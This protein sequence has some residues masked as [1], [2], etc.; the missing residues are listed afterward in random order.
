MTVAVPPHAVTIR[1]FSPGSTWLARLW[2]H[3]WL[4]ASV[5]VA[6]GAVTALISSVPMPRGPV[7]SGEGLIVIGVSVV[8]GVVAGYLMRSR[9]ALLLAPLAYVVTYELARLGIAGATMDGFRF[10]TVYGIAAF[11]VGRGFHGLLALFP[12]VVGV[13]IGLAVARPRR[14]LSLLPTGILVAAVVGLAV[15]VA[16]P[17]STPP[18]LGADGQPVPGSIA[19]LSTVELGG[20]EQGISIRAS[21]PD[22]PVLLYL[23]G[24]PGQTD[25]AFGRVLL[26][27]LTQDF[28]VVVWDQR[29]TGMSYGALDP[30]ESATLDQAVADTIELSTYL[31]ARFDEERIYLLGESWGTTLGVLAAQE[32]PDLYHAYIGSGQMVSQR[33][34]DQIIW[35]DLLAYADRSGDGQLY[36]QIL[37]LGEPPYRDTP[38]A[39][40]IVMG[41]YPLLE[42]PYTPPAAYVERGTASD[43]GPYT[44]LASEY[45]FV[46]KANV[47]RGLLDTFSIMYPQL[48]PIDFRADVPELEVPVW[49]LDGANEIRGRRELALEWFEQ[50]AAPSKEL[51]TYA[52]AGH[53]V[54]FEQADAFHRLMVDEIVPA[55]YGAA[56]EE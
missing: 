56:G 41:Y 19:E 10:D 4:G 28:V 40:S 32:R 31:A 27:P 13:S 14:L 52:D 22:D 30:A 24:G 26:E 9:W 11:V 23:S 46:D 12:M 7:S 6:I 39:N 29:G 5:V 48:Q 51:V 47:I 38:W 3:R 50:L 15:L 53:S 49:V 25:L 33:V 2:T 42:T 45:G 36:D 44:V 18:I 34:T 55:T 21:D 54:V 43:L 35:R 17:A 16:L 8:I 37:T 1:S 20:Q